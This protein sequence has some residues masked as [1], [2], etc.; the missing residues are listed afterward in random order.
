MFTGKRL[1]LLGFILLLLIATPATVYFLQQQQETRS[2]ADATTTMAFYADTNITTP[3]TQTNPLTKNVGDT[4]PV[5]IALDP[6]SNSVASAILYIKYDPAKL[7][8]VDTPDVP[9]FE[10]NIAAFRPE[11]VQGPVYSEDEVS[12]WITTGTDVTT[13]I[14]APNKPRVGT[15]MFRAKAATGG[16]PTQVTFTPETRINAWGDNA[17]AKEN[18]LLQPNPAYI[19]INGG[20]N[21]TTEPTITPTQAPGAVATAT[22]TPVAAAAVVTATPTQVPF[23]EATPTLAETGPGEIVMGMGA[24][25]GVIMVIGALLFFVL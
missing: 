13:A 18:V 8:I 11:P 25:A 15:V 19:V 4:F 10:R 5:V 3:I 2:R 16:T 17:T 7:E 24:L 9:G 12:V 14:K 20:G 23:I 6:G 21:T 22:P 1:L